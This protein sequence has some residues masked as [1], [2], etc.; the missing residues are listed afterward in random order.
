MCIVSLE[1]VLYIYIKICYIGTSK[2]WPLHTQFK[3]STI[4]SSLQFYGASLKT[5][6]ICGSHTVYAVFIN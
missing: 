4:L 6:L 2:T 5:K 1:P 3:A